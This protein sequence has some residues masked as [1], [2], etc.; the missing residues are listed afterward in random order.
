LASGTSFADNY[1]NS[2]RPSTKAKSLIERTGKVS[3]LNFDIFSSAE[4]GAKFVLMDYNL[5]EP[6]RT[7]R[8]TINRTISNLEK[9]GGMS[10]KDRKVINA[11]NNAFEESV[12]NLVSNTYIDSSIVDDVVDEISRQ[13]YRGV[14]AGTGRF[15]AELLSNVGFILISDPDTFTE[16]L[17]NISMIMSPDA[18]KVMNNVN[19]KETNRI[20]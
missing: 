11:I 7:A 4:R 3:P 8:K 18:P 16:G 6:I 5:T 1:N 10:Q 17:K 12:E 9:D 19:S 13:G 14:L 15:G 2:L 20:I